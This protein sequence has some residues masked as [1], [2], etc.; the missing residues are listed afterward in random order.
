VSGIVHHVDAERGYA[1]GRQSKVGKLD[2]AAT[3]GWSIVDIKR[4]WNRILSA[5]RQGSMTAISGT[6]L[7]P[8]LPGGTAAFLRRRR[9]P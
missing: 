7:Y 9:S 6:N 2:E 4:G 8:G 3:R 1:C 5:G